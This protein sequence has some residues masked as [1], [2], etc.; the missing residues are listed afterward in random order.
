MTTLF[1]SC[2]S[3]NLGDNREVTGLFSRIPRG[4][5]SEGKRLPNRDV[6]LQVLAAAHAQIQEMHANS[7]SRAVGYVIVVLLLYAL[8]LVVALV[9][10][11]I[12]NG[13]LSSID[14]LS[15]FG[16]LHSQDSLID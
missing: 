10:V 16:V 3:G 13:L 1:L 6:L 11:R 4:I 9:K 7:G 15:H 8:A 14:C 2:R 12:K 5:S